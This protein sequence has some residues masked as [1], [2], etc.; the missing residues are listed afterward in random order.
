MSNRRKERRQRETNSI[1]EVFSWLF[2]I[3]LA[4]AAAFII[5]NYII[6]NANI[7]SGSMENTIMTGDRIIGFRLA[8]LF[9]E[10]KRGDIII[11]KFP[12][13]ESQNFIKRIIGLPGE[14]VTIKEGKIYIDNAQE[15]LQEDYLPEQWT[16]YMGPYYFSVPE[17]SYLVLGDNRNYSKDARFWNQT[18]VS[19]DKILGEALFRYYPFSNAGSL[20]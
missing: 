4:I 14:T 2:T 16:N 19:S 9:E 17:D 18:Y 20:Y 12:D 3:T 7:P 13:D 15:P 11:F 5:K 1:K 10:P 6:I 8:Y